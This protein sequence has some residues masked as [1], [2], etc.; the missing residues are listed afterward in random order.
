MQIESV[1]P[2]DIHWFAEH[3]SN[4]CDL[5]RVQMGEVEEGT[6]TDDSVDSLHDA[7]LQLLIVL[8]DYDN[9]RISPSW[10]QR[11]GS[12]TPSIGDLGDYG[13]SILENLC[14]FSLELELDLDPHQWEKLSISL[15][16]WGINRGAD[17]SSFTLITNGLAHIANNATTLKHLELL[18][19]TMSETLEA[20]ALDTVEEALFNDPSHPWRILLF[21][22]AIVATRSLSPHFIREAFSAIEEHL[23]EEAPEF[24]SEGLIHLEEEEF[25]QETKALV[26]EFYKNCRKPVLH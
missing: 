12:T 13:L 2:A 19:T 16:R 20:A 15:A 8:Q 10:E 17:I 22:R 3:F 6:N 18:Y 23:P 25:P 26:A 24:F 14:Q 1:P 11:Y 4:T 21:N 7:M 5:L 9:E